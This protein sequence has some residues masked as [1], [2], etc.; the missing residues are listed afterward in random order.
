MKGN[1][2]AWGRHAVIESWRRVA[3]G[4]V[5]PLLLAIEVG[6]LAIA[7]LLVLRACAQAAERPV[8]APAGF[9]AFCARHPGDCA[10]QGPAPAFTKL[11]TERWA[12]LRTVQTDINARILWMPDVATFGESDRWDYPLAWGDCEDIAL[13]KRRALVSL[14][15]PAGN[16]PLALA[17][18]SDGRLHVVLLAITG[19]GVFVLD[20]LRPG[21][22]RT[23]DYRLL[24]RQS[25][26]DP[27]AWISLIRP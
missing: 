5:R 6:L 7:T 15:W 1:A 13:A 24:A 10:G 2:R 19:G 23:A 17:R 14:G 22:A 8:E 18:L 27:S 3:A 26:A 20:N 21:L 25:R 9:V 4:C 11:S 12:E 16:L